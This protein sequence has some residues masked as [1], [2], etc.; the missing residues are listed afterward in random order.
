M[1]VILVLGGC[2]GWR[3][4]GIRLVEKYIEG[5]DGEEEDEET[6][7]KICLVDINRG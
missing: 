2:G 3:L 5:S 4:N 6:S 7:K 1:V